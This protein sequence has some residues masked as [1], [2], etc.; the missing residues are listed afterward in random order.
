VNR[1]L[2][3]VNRPLELV[4]RPLELVNRPGSYSH[5]SPWSW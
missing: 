1:P 5:N 3:L 2:E 4:N